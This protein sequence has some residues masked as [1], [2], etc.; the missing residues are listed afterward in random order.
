[1]TTTMVTT[2]TTQKTTSSA[3]VDRGRRTSTRRGR[4]V[5]L[6]WLLGAN[7]GLAALQPVVVTRSPLAFV[8]CSARPSR[9]V[10]QSVRAR[11]LLPRGRHLAGH[12]WLRDVSTSYGQPGESRCFR[13]AGCSVSVTPELRATAN[14]RTIRRR[15]LL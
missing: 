14:L 6:S 2:S 3:A 9:S 12:L 7:D 5:E 4:A 1:M 15:L 11:V 13:G 10:Q 8:S